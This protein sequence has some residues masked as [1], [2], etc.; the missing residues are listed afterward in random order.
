MT[1][2]L[3]VSIV[4]AKVPNSVRNLIVVGMYYGTDNAEN[5]RTA[6]SDFSAQLEALKTIPVPV[7]KDPDGAMQELPIKLFLTGD[8]MFITSCSWTSR[9]EST[10]SVSLLSRDEG[11]SENSDMLE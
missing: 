9:A 1:T 10:F 8:T 4:N 11:K 2:K 3:S 7:T 6:F 5:L